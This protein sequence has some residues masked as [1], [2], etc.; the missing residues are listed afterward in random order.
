[1]TKKMHIILQQKH[2]DATV[3]AQSAMF[4]AGREQS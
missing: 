1:M 4:T 3:Q 2:C